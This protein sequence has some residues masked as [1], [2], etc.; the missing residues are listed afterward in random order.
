MST[1]YAL[2]P[3]TIPAYPQIEEQLS[4]TYSFVM[5]D[6]VES[7]AKYREEKGVVMLGGD[8]ER[9]NSL[10]GMVRTVAPRLGC[11]IVADE[12]I[13]D[14]IDEA[15]VHQADLLITPAKP[16]EISARFNLA[17]HMSELRH[18]IEASAQLDEV[19]ELYN[20]QYFL[21]RLGE[22]ISL[23][24]RH[25]SPVTCVI[26]SISYYDVYMDSYGYD[27]VS[28]FMHQV[29]LVVKEHIRREDI[30][31][32]LGDSEIAF[33]LPRSSERG[34]LI[35]ANRIVS[36]VQTLPLYMGDQIEHL[37]LNAG[38]AGYPAVDESEM[39]AD[40]LIRYTRHALHHARCSENQTIQLFSEMK[41]HVP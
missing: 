31:A 30:A 12:S 4:K 26:V 15:T 41:P 29:A 36:K 21:K 13:I 2:F 32:R 35:L 40:T 14:K 24:K 3:G 18:L 22:E 1:I 8:P 11:V 7:L 25:L 27:F 23:A 37:H 33:L 20:Y 10:I 17:V 28:N 38:V 19:T 39:D 5:V 34:A 9:I 6:K 16:L